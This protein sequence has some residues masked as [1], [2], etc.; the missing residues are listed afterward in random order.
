MMVVTVQGAPISSFFQGPFSSPGFKTGPRAKLHGSVSKTPVWPNLDAIL[1]GPV[2]K[3]V[4]LNGPTCCCAGPDT[5]ADST[6]DALF[7]FMPREVTAKQ[8]R[9]A[10]VRA[11]STLFHIVFLMS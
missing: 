1:A 9:G 7:G 5:M 3:P 10:I 8:V 2:L 4:L 11:D 6:K